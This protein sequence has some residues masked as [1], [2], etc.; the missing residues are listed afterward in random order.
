M[1]KHFRLIFD[2][3]Y[4]KLFDYQK[5]IIE[6]KGSL[7]DENLAHKLGQAYERNAKILEYLETR[8]TEGRKRD[9]KKNKQSQAKIDDV[10]ELYKRR[11]KECV[12][13]LRKILEIN[14]ENRI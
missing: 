4:E 14:K 5:I 7:L 3:L 9:E 11:I 13:L 1:A 10:N 6:S 12:T 8:E 2:K